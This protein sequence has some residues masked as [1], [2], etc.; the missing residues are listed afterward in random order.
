MLLSTRYTL[1]ALLGLLIQPAFANTDLYDRCMN[2]AKEVNNQQLYQ[3]AEIAGKPVRKQLNA[4]YMNLYKRLETERPDQAANLELA[5][6][7]WLESRKLN[8]QLQSA[9]IGSPMGVLCELN[10]NQARQA[11]LQQ[12][13]DSGF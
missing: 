7:A 4:T 3:C 13:L 9:L 10:A 12:L 2:E 8:C 6:K 5:Q 11:E 1:P